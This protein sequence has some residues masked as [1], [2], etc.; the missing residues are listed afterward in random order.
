MMLILGKARTATLLALLWQNYCHAWTPPTTRYEGCQ[1]QQ[2][3]QQQ[4]QQQ[5]ESELSRDVRKSLAVESNVP[6]ETFVDNRRR[7]FLLQTGLASM[8]LGL[9]L[10]PAKANL[11]PSE[12]RRIEVFER[13]APSVVFIDTFTERR[14]VFSTNVMEVPLGTGSGYVW[15]DDGHIVT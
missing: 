3:Q 10:E 4:T 14:D 1:Q 9:N 12:T 6:E 8:A 2:R 13:V 7:H 11:D 15:D 5:Q